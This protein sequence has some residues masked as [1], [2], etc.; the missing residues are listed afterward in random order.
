MMV[1]QIFSHILLRNLLLCKR[2]MEHH[3]KGMTS[4]N[5]DLTIE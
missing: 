4:K 5:T 1:E 2:E 3:A